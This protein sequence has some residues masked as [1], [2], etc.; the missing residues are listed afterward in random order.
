MVTKVLTNYARVLMFL[1]DLVS[2]PEDCGQN[3]G[4][5]GEFN[6]PSLNLV[7]H[8]CTASDMSFTLKQSLRQ[9][10]KPL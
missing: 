2:L 6:R 3:S 5:Q 8:V 4:H 10:Q 7:S 9:H 1:E